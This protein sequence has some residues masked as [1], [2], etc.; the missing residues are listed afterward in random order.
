M[1]SLNCE[2]VIFFIFYRDILITK[3]LKKRSVS[4]FPTL[5]KKI[6]DTFYKPYLGYVNYHVKNNVTGQLVTLVS[7]TLTSVL[8]IWLV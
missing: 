1:P 3:G 8:T 5:H 7:S 6:A 4:G 2:Y